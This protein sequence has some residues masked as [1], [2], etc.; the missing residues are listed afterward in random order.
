MKPRISK[1]TTRLQLAALITAAFE[2]EGMSA[3]LVGGAVVSLYTNNQYESYDL[4]FISSDDQ[5]QITAVMLDLGFKKVGKNFEHP[6][7]PL[8]VEFPSGPIAIGNQVPVQPEG[9][10]KT[11]KTTITLLSPT[12]CV[13]DRLAAWYHWND[14]QSLEQAVL[15]SQSQPIK[16]AAIKKWSEAEG[17]IEKF[18]RYLARLK[19]QK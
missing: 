13:M 10:I 17:E 2:K 19:R 9:S 1:K 5:K 11:G 4:D 12:Q 3:T 15:V 6:E 18:E 14:T 8:F 16:I 7:T